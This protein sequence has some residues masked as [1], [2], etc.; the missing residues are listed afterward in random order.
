MW[1]LW[2]VHDVLEDGT[3]KLPDGQWEP[4]LSL[5]EMDTATRAMKRPGSGHP[6]R[7]LDQ[8]G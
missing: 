1:E 8:A 3:R 4:A 5:A 7:T 6:G 2:R